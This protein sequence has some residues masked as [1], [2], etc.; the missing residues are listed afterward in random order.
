MLSFLNF[1]FFNLKRIN[2]SVLKGTWKPLGLRKMETTLHESLGF[3]NMENVQAADRSSRS[4]IWKNTS[5]LS[6]LEC[7]PVH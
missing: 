3:P 6:E 7:T 1:F 5:V 2:L 4:P